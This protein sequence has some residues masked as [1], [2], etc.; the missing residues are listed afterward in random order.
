MANKNSKGLGRGIDAI[1]KDFESPDLSANNT[2]E[3]LPLV[4]IRHNPYQPRKTFDQEG[5][6]EL[7]DSIKQTGVFQPI[8]VR[9]SVSGYESSQVNG[10]FGRQNWPAR[11]PFPPLFATLTIRK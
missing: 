3:E 1:F 6:K 9:K 10:A 8:I 5:L 7:A 2:V 4:D 11:K